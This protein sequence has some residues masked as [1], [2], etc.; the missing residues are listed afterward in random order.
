MSQRQPRR[1][2]WLCVVCY[3]LVVAAVVFAM[4]AARKSALQSLSTEKSVS[5]WRLF[6]E[7]VRQQQSEGPLV[8][9]RVP[10]SDEPP[11][12][13]LLRD[14]F[15]VSL[16]GAVLFSTVLFWVMAWLVLGATTARSNASQPVSTGTI[17]RQ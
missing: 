14:H 11:A 1:W 3:F 4:I 8:E 13:V 5:D 17:R 2:V 12:L 6:Q 16:V 9:R 10:K 15:A 7:D